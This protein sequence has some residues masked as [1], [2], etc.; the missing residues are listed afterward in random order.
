MITTKSI[1][2]V[3]PLLFA[4]A[5]SFA[6]EPEPKTNEPNTPRPQP[7]PPPG[8]ELIHDVEIGTGGGRP[9]HAEIARPK[10]PSTAPMPAVIWIHGGGWSGGSHKGNTAVFLAT[11]GYFTASIEYRLSGEAKWPAQIED[12]KLG[13]RW[14][15]ANAAKYNIDPARIGCWGSSAGGHLVACLGVMDDPRFEGSGGYAGVSSGVQAVCDFYGPADMTQGSA[16]I[17]GAQ[18]GQDAQAPLGLFGAP[19]KDKPE[20]WRDGSPIVHVKA[21]D[22]PFLI[23]HGDADKTV[24]HEHSEKFVAALQ[25][26]GVPVELITVQ[27][28]GHNLQAQPGETPAEP[29]RD[30]IN[31]AVLAFFN[32]VLRK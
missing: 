4:A 15:R 8:V 23:V 20:L 21:G 27:R 16:G 18:D 25:K 17:Q 13:V 19:F 3:I 22:P 32:K 31:A 12:C 2:L 14:L 26:A 28:G 24:P 30:A 29:G 5:L 7:P 11:K 1:R 10:D 9:L 6:A